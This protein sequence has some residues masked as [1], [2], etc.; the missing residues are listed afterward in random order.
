VGLAGCVGGGAISGNSAGVAGCG[1]EASGM[2]ATLGVVRAGTT[3]VAAATLPC[4]PTAA[5]V[6][7]GSGGGLSWHWKDA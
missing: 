2:A 7:P 5:A 1:I 3:G 4:L 6:L